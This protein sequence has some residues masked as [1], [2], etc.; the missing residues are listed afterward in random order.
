MKNIKSSGYEGISNE[1]LKCCPPIVE[2]Y[3]AKRINK[4]IFQEIFPDCLKKNTVLPLN[5]T[6]DKNQ[7]GNYRPISLISQLSKVFE[8]VLLKRMMKLCDKHNIF[9]RT[10]SSFRPKKSGIHAIATVTHSIRN[11]NDKKNQKV[12]RA[13]LILGSQ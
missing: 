3:P 1:I 12:K 7:P 8:K 6:G 10:Q 4:C 11:E 13:L 9:L 2:H 5:K